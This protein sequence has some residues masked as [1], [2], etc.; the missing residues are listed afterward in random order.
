MKKTSE[1]SITQAM[2]S[3]FRTIL[4]F[5][6]VSLIGLGLIGQLSVDLLPKSSE[7]SLELSYRLPQSPPEV[8]EQSV[9]S[10]LENVFSQLSDL[11]K[12][13]S[14]SRY[15]AGSIRL[16]F[17]PKASLDFKRLEVAS[18]IRRIYPK[19]P[20]QTS[21][22]QLRRQ[23][24]KQGDANP[25]LIYSINAPLA[26]YRIQEICEELLKIPL[27]TLSD[28]DRLE[29]EGAGLP[30]IVVDFDQNK[31]LLYQILQE[32]ILRAI[33][34]HTENIALGSFQNTAGQTFFIKTDSKL[35]SLQDIERIFIPSSKSDALKN[36]ANDSSLS[37]SPGSGVALGEIAE[38][39]MQEQEARQYLRINGLNSVN[40]IIYARDHINQLRLAADIQKKIQTLSL[41]AGFQIIKEYDHTEHL[42][43]EL[44]KIYTRTGL[45]V[46]VL[47][48]MILLLYHNL[49]YLFI[50]LSCLWVNLCW[51]AILLY[52]LGINIHLYS[53]AGLTLSF[54]LILDNAI[55]MLDHLHRYQRKNIDAFFALLGATLTTIAA[56]G[57]IFLLPQEDR[58]N[59]SDFALVIVLNLGVSLVLA[60][61]YIPACYDV[62]GLKKTAAISLKTQAE[63]RRTRTRLRV[64]GYYFGFIRFLRRYRTVFTLSLVLGFGLPVFL[65]PY[66]IEG[67]DFYNQTL[68]TDMYQEEI[69][70]YTDKILGGASRLFYQNVYENSGYRSPEETKLYVQAEMPFGVTL[71]QMNEIIIKAEKFLQKV[72]GLEKFVTLVHSGQYARIEIHFEKQYAL[73][74][75]PYQ[76]KADLIQQSLDWGGVKW[77][78]YGV[79]E[80]FSNASGE[81][82]AS[83]RVE[84]R[85]YQYDLLENEVQKL[86]KKLLK[87]KRIQK[88]NVHERLS[89]DEKPSQEFVLFL[90]SKKLNS[91]AF[92]LLGITEALLQKSKSN[93]AGLSLNYANQSIPLRLQES[94]AADFSAYHLQNTP[95]LLDTRQRIKLSDFGVISLESTQNSLHKENRQYIRVIGFDY[96]GS[97]R[98]GEQFLDQTLEEMK[99][100]MPIGFEAKKLEYRFDLE[101]TKRQYALLLLLLIAIFFICAILFESFS[102]PFLIILT[103]PI[104]FIGLFLIFAWGE[105]YFD[106]GGYAAF[107]LLGGLVVNA[108]IFVLHD[109]NHLTHIRRHNHRVIKAISG[110]ANAI[111]LTT[112]STILGLAPFLTEGDTEIFW[113][114]LAIGAIGGL[115]FS[116][117]AVFICLPVWLFEKRS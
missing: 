18:I 70:P 52:V 53:L 100:E 88:V 16:E 105:F 94:R 36:Q 21:Y 75:L 107:V 32:D 6:I 106:Q 79:G 64:Y 99:K 48:G 80:G 72:Q 57:L 66:Q 23:S 95:L 37:I 60:L 74:S 26:S 69:R 41:P 103:I 29:I 47:I 110:K 14:T 46:A 116:L 111:F 78:I 40:L 43:E 12:I 1:A 87:H 117:F 9:T 67:W 31:M 3:P 63:R 83:F 34:N 59:L 98:F 73:S 112:L 49:K 8:V 44:N 11:K 56:L 51:T 35:T 96:Y 54:G 93:Q 97:P 86:A 28:I 101:K 2:L 13:N 38:V 30:E 91:A 68:G 76:L 39:Y 89:Y 20:P 42:S 61:F 62:F 113:F 102:A 58:M 104:S 25:L 33:R 71:D 22:P 85:G 55:V 84:M 10:V 4:F 77:N 24:N 90:D 19:L 108:S 45:S 92:S 81:N 17:D 5:W 50:L 82:L 7:S 114:S 15:N 27:S 115:I 65:L 109:F